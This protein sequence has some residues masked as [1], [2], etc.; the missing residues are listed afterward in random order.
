VDANSP[1]LGRLVY[2][3]QAISAKFHWDG[4]DSLERRAPERMGRVIFNLNEFAYAD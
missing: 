1:H 4:G 2:V 3:R